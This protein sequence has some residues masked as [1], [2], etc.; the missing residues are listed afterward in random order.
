MN[1][2]ELIEALAGKTGMTISEAA[3]VVEA[4]FSP[5]TGVISQALRNGEKVKIA[6]FGTFSVN[7]RAARIG[8]NPAT[9]AQINLRAKAFPS[10]KP[11]K[12]LKDTIHH[13]GGGG[14]R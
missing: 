14:G 8:R 3:K 6:G 9:G 11:G 13:H 2:S 5:E 1:K 4:I 12:G 10:F 7:Q